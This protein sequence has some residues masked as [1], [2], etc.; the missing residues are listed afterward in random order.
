MLANIE[1]SAP[2]R[3]LGPVL[4]KL[5]RPA[6]GFRHPREVLKDPLLDTAQKRAIL[7]SWAS[8]ASAVEDHPTLR[9]LL[10]TEAPVPV[11]EILDA[12]WRLDGQAAS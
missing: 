6:V 7:S 12:L 4:E 9:W 3:G 11:D 5:L 8:D 10:G 1:H 2:V